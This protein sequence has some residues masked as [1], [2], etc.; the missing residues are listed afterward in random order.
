MVSRPAQ[1]PLE[2]ALAEA[3]FADA[4]ARERLGAAPDDPNAREAVRHAEAQLE[5][6]KSAVRRALR[7]P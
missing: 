1:S 3:L 2:A 7:G 4:A 6:A 5:Q